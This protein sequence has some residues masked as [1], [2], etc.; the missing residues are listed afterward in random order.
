M[1][2]FSGSVRSNLDPFNEYSDEECWDV[3]ERC[4]LGQRAQ[5]MNQSSSEITGRILL[6]SL[7]TPVSAGG[8]S[9]S[10]GQRQLLALARAML[11]RSAVVIMD[12]ATSSIDLETDD[13]VS[14]SLVYTQLA[15]FT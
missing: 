13:Q 3:L 1:A 15:S 7:D 12:E 5:I 2:L 4:H 11:R 8:K 10:A 14:H 9:F 6:S